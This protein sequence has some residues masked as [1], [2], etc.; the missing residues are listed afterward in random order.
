VADAG[1]VQVFYGGS[2]GI[3]QEPRY[4]NLHQNKGSTAGTA[5]VEDRFGKAVAVLDAGPW[6]IYLPLVIRGAGGP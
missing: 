5:E 6:K 2:F 3:P 4:D 1:M